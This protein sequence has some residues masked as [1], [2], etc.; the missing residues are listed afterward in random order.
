MVAGFTMAGMPASSVGASFSSIPQTG[1]L[2]GVD[3]HG[4]ALERHADVP[5]DERAALR[6]GLGGPLHVERL[7]GE[8]AAPARCVR[9]QRADAPS[10]S[11][12]LSRRVAPVAAEM[13]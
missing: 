2:K 12:Q 1:K 10:M 6:Q 13:A 4:H 11:T 7:V 8:L 3:V 9:E 5:P